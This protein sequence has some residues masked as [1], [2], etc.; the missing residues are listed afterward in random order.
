MNYETWNILLWINNSTLLQPYW[1]ARARS[2]KK[3]PTYINEYMS[4]DRRIVTE[5][6]KELDAY[7]DEQAEKWGHDQAS[8]FADIFNNAL[9]AINWHEIA[10]SLLTDILEEQL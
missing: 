3:H 8:C 9:T 6:A 4:L 5:L 1:H 2:I 10:E 7:F